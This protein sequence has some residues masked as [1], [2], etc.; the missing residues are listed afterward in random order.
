MAGR[1]AR[2]Q[3]RMPAG[4]LW[5]AATSAHQVEGGDDGTDWWVAEQA[6]LVPAASGAACDHR[7]LYARDLDLLAGAGLNAYRFSVGG[8]SIRLP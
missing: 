8:V 1:R 4:F 3:P 6:G 7:C 5:G 2:L